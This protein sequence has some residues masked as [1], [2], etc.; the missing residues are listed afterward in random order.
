MPPLWHP[1]L[2]IPLLLATADRAYCKQTPDV[3]VQQNGLTVTVTL[4]SQSGAGI[5]AS[6]T[7]SNITGDWRRHTALL[8]AN[9]TDTQAVLSITATGNEVALDM[10]SLF[11]EANGLGGETTPFRQDLLGLLKDLQPG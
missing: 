11:P 7:F 4:E 5:Y 6:A 1:D 10:V 3:H 9:A 2:Y 8:A